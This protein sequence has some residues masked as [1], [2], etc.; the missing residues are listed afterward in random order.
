MGGYKVAQIRVQ[1]RGFYSSRKSPR[2]NLRKSKFLVIR[3][4]LVLFEFFIRASLN[5]SVQVSESE[6]IIF[7]S[8]RNLYFVDQKGINV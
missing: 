5:F 6:R 8:N 2:M 4:C 7:E 3:A 1:L